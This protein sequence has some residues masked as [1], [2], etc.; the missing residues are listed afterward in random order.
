MTSIEHLQQQ[1][2]DGIAALTRD[3]QWITL[4]ELTARTGSRYSLGNLLLIGAQRPQATVVCG[5]RTWRKAGR[6]VRHGERG[7]RILAPI[8]ARRPRPGTEPGPRPS[9]DTTGDATGAVAD[10]GTTGQ[11]TPASGS[12]AG[13]RT[14]RP[15]QVVGFRP[16]VVFDIEQTDGPPRPGDTA[17]DGYTPQGLREA[18][19]TQI[20]H[21]GYQVKVGGCGPAFGRTRRTDRTVTILPGQPPAQDALTLAHELGHLACGHLD[22]DTGYTHRGT[23]E[24]EAESVAYIL[25]AA[26]GMDTT[27]ASFDYIGTWAQGDLDL[28]RTTADTVIRVARPLL[29]ALDLAPAELTTPTAAAADTTDATT[30]TDLVAGT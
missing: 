21:R 15:G 27:A 23:A 9:G 30:G 8:I 22:D 19:T 13:Q 20:N 17:I 28:L 2:T 25:L 26:A 11:P 16:V 14:R 4:L 10:T 24:I 1:I 18:L 6:Q 12:G 3:Q 29:A 5:Y 7:I